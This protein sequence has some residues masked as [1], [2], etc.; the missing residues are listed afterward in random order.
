[1]LIAGA[2][3]FR[4]PSGTKNTAVIVFVSTILLYICKYMITKFTTEHWDQQSNAKV[5]RPWESG[6]R[7]AQAFPPSDRSLGDLSYRL[8]GS[9]AQGSNL[10][11][12]NAW[13][14][15]L[16]MIFWKCSSFQQAF[17]DPMC[18]NMRVIECTIQE[19]DCIRIVHSIAFFFSHRIHNTSSDIL[20][21]V[22]THKLKCT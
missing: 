7:H 3:F 17:P 21:F 19:S 14:R 9:R 6:S 20:L 22:I 4:P 10:K 18:K 12:N 5:Y 11:K 13:I 16:R 15:C 1:M 8:R 2:V